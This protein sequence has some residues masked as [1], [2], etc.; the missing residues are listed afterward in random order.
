M[1]Q[2]PITFSKLQKVDQNRM[3]EMEMETKA[4]E[5]ERVLIKSQKRPSTPSQSDDEFESADDGPESTLKER[6]KAS[7]TE[8]D[9]LR[10]EVFLLKKELRETQDHIFSMQP[11]AQGL[12]ESEALADFN[13]LWRGVEEWVQ[14]KLSDSIE[15]ILEGN[16]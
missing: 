2:T 13:S 3:E 10:N 7:K 14:S 8:A 12:T 5:T 6:F 1:S 16:Q 4:Y 15:A 11:R 9:I